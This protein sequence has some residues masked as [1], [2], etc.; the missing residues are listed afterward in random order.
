M[1]SLNSPCRSHF[2]LSSFL[3]KLNNRVP[4]GPVFGLFIFSLYSHGDFNVVVQ[5]YHQYADT[6]PFTF[7]APTTPP[8]LLLY[9]ATNLYLPTLHLCEEMGAQGPTH[10]APCL[11]L[12][13]DFCH[14][15]PGMLPVQPSQVILNKI[16]I[17]TDT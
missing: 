1:L 7:P 13:A 4:H 15:L 17:P 6:L 2:L 16:A 14:P 8:F 5:K 3:P 9:P 11:P 10:V 12:T